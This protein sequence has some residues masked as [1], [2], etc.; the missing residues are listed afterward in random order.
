VDRNFKETSRL[1]ISSGERFRIR[2][3]SSKLVEDAYAA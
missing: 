2:D 3:I 1:T